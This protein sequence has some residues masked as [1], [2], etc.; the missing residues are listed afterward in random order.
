MVIHFQASGRD[1]MGTAQEHRDIRERALARATLTIA[2][3]FVGEL[4]VEHIQLERIEPG[5]WAII[6]PAWRLHPDRKAFDIDF[7]WLQKRNKR[8]DKVDVSIWCGDELCGMFLAKLSRRRINFALRFLESSP[9]PHPLEGYMIP[10]GLFIAEAFAYEYGVHQVMV[11]RPAKSLV[12]LYRDWGY[13]LDAADLSREKRN[14]N[15]RA[16]ALTK[17]MNMQVRVFNE[18]S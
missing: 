2:E 14:C 12:P 15:T 7:N 3:K 1:Q 8:R 17:K 13:E 11:S 16:K 4:P 18:Q 5:H 9:F 6:H 10:I